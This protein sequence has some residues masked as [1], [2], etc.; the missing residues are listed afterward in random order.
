MSSLSSQP[1]EVSQ[2]KP[3]ETSAP[4]PVERPA[5]KPFTIKLHTVIPV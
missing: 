5:S 2:P 3:V 4:R 1:V